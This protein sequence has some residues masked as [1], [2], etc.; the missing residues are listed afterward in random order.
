[1]WYCPGGGGAVMYSIVK[2]ADTCLVHFT[3][4]NIK[5][6]FIYVC[7]EGK[8][9]FQDMQRWVK[10]QTVPNLEQCH[11]M[12]SKSQSRQELHAHGFRAQWLFFIYTYFVLLTNLEKPL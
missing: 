10:P 12:A 3:L 4:T 5:D 11:D 8:H 2:I 6:V 7:K 1:M 9:I